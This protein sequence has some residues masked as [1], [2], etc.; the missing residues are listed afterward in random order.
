MLLAGRIPASPTNTLPATGA[1]GTTACRSA[2]DPAMRARTASG[3][4]MSVYG[5]QGPGSRADLLLPVPRRDERRTR[6]RPCESRLSDFACVPRRHDMRA[7]EGAC[8]RCCCSICC[9]SCASRADGG[10]HG[11]IGPTSGPARRATT[12]SELSDVASIAAATAASRAAASCAATEAEEEEERR[13]RWGG[14]F[15]SRSNRHSAAA[16]E[17]SSSVQREGG[18][19]PPAAARRLG[20]CGSSATTGL[21]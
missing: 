20:R 3:L 18:G 4:S 21:R 13:R 14:G 5:V 17:C 9:L 16:P 2:C 15:D 6:T 19:A 11:D 10:S 1:S 8:S 7:G 12:K